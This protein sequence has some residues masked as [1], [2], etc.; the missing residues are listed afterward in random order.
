MRELQGLLNAV[1]DSTNNALRIT[2]GGLFVRK[3]ADETVTASTT[4]QD[5]DHLLL[6]LAAS[7]TYTF[8]AYL[9]ATSPTAADIKVAFT[10]PA[11]ATINYGFTAAP[12]LGAAA[13]ANNSHRFEHS[14][15]SGTGITAG[16]MD[17][18]KVDIRIDGIVRT[19]G[20]A[21]NLRLQFAQ[22]TSD[23]GNTVL[24]TDS[25]LVA[26]KVA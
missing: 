2:G 10:A 13:A 25:Y 4:L 20:T 22:G 16:G 24:Y 26:E 9:I 14:A 11:G 6:A 17:A 8:S 1:F 5:D 3:T 7:S 19:A 15:A 18:L 12:Q 23:V 21:G